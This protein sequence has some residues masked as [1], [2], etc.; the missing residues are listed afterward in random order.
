MNT[1][2]PGTVAQPSDAL[3]MK[4]S[5]GIDLTYAHKIPFNYYWDIVVANGPATP[6]AP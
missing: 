2:V 3:A 1:A 5:S 4:A 6:V